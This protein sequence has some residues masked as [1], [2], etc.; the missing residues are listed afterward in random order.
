MNALIPNQPGNY[1]GTE[2]KNVEVASG[3]VGEYAN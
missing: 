3:V 1:A 2:K